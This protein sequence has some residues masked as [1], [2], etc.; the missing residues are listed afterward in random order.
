MLKVFGKPYRYSAGGKKFDENDLPRGYF[1]WYRAPYI[2]FAVANDRVGEIRVLNR[3][4]VLKNGLRVG[5][6]LEDV[7]A[8]LGRK[9]E[10]VGGQR[11]S[12]N[13]PNVLFR[14]PYGTPDTARMYL[15]DDPVL[16]LFRN[17]IVNQI[18]L[19]GPESP[20]RGPA[21]E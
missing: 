3:G 2:L 12:R 9:P 18:T 8:A 17:D 21:A 7:A 1:M 5:A 4:Y 11:A 19:L 14:E 16:L 6:S 15:A 13:R 20:R 10:E